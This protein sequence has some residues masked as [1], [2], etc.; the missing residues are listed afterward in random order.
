MRFYQFFEFFE[1]GIQF[2]QYATIP[3]LS[4]SW[5]LTKK[6]LKTRSRPKARMGMK[7]GA[8]GV[9]VYRQPRIYGE[10]CLTKTLNATRFTS[11][12]QTFL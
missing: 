7:N 11:D 6:L 4:K 2:Y 1:A 5:R 8:E 9:Y 3:E 12:I 10:E